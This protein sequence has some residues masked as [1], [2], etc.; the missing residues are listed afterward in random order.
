MSSVSI[1]E[2]SADDA[3]FIYA[4]CLEYMGWK[5]AFA[6]KIRFRFLMIFIKFRVTVHNYIQIKKNI[7][8]KENPAR[9]FLF[10][11]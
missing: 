10:L 9:C 4:T 5:W 11:T 6:T 1:I 2:S 3:C 7:T 8:E